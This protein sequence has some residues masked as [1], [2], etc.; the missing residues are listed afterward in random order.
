MTFIPKLDLVGV[1]WPVCL[2]KFK[3]AVN[4][5]CACEILDVL[6]QDPDVVDSINMIVDRSEDTLINQQKDG[7]VYRLSIQK[8]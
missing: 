3:S 6:T 2:L 1:A 4:G 5:L 8:G 7:Q